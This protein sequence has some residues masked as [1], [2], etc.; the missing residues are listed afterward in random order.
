MIESE[1]KNKLFEAIKTSNYEAV[2]NSNYASTIIVP[3][4]SAVHFSNGF[5]PLHTSIET[6]WEN[7]LKVASKKPDPTY[8]A[9]SKIFNLFLKAPIAHLNRTL[10]YLKKSD[11]D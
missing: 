3:N 10:P 5:T 11:L 9:D 6:R 2:K 4:M 8:E 1:D 7:A